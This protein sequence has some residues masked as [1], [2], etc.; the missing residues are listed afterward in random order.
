[1]KVKAVIKF[2]C[3]ECHISYKLIR[4]WDG[5]V[6]HQDLSVDV[7]WTVMNFEA[8]GQDRDNWEVQP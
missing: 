8:Y 2:R 7:R 1:M 3:A 4:H 5:S 6:E